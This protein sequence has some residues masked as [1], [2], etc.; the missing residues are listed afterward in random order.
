VLAACKPANI[1][2]DYGNAANTAPR[3]TV[4]WQE[5]GDDPGT[6]WDALVATGPSGYQVVECKW[7][8]IA[9]G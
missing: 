8:G 6:G 9:H 3:V 7:K 2:G 1:L 4:G 5:P